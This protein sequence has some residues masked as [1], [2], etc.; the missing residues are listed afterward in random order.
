MKFKVGDFVRRAK[1]GEKDTQ[2][3]GV[4]IHAYS[5]TTILGH[6]PELYDVEWTRPVQ[7]IERGF[8]PHGLEHDR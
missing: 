2:P 7:K 6:Y 5:K 1:R 8:L 3:H 4:V